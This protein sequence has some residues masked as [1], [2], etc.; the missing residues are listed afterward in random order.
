[1]ESIEKAYQRRLAA[2]ASKRKAKKPIIKTVSDIQ[3]VLAELSPDAQ[4]NNSSIVSTDI[5]VIDGSGNIV[6]QNVSIQTNSKD[7]R[8]VLLEGFTLISK[9]LQVIE[10][11]KISNLEYPTING[12]ASVPHQAINETLSTNVDEILDRLLGAYRDG[13][14]ICWDLDRFTYS[15]DIFNHKLVKRD[16]HAED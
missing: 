8:Q 9:R 12:R 11:S 13:L 3:R 6:N 2:T 10:K 14:M 4:L 7:H 1:M 5:P 15:Y 16:K